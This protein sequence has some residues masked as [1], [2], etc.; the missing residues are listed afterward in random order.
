MIGALVASIAIF[1][2][3]AL[4]MFLLAHQHEHVRQLSWL[5]AIVR[6]VVAGFIGVLVSVTIQLGLHSLVDVKTVALAIGSVLVLLVAKKDPV[7]VI[8][9]AALLSPFLFS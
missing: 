1:T 4:A 5:Q 2:P 9:G 8:L 7:W 6:G 3:G